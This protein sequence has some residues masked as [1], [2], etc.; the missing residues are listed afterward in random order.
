MRLPTLLLLLLTVGCSML[1][2][3]P[4]DPALTSPSASEDHSDRIAWWREARFGL[5]IHW[6]LY[7]VLA[8]EV[9][10][11]PVG[12]V[13]EWI[14][15]IGRIPKREYSKLLDR[16]DPVAF[17]ADEWARIAKDAGMRYLVITTKHHDGFALF[18]SAVSDFDVMAT[19][20]HRDI[21]AELAA[22]CRRHG[23]R[24][25][26]Y[27][28]ILDW[29]HPDHLP[30]ED[31]HEMSTEGASY[32]R[33]VAFLKSQVTELLTHYGPIDILWFDGEW[34]PTWTNAYA[35]ELESLVRSLQPGILINNRIGKA[36]YP[37][38]TP[39]G[40]PVPGDFGT[41][42]QHIP[43]TGTPGVDW[44][45][46][47]TMND[48][49]GYK[50]ADDHWKS[51]ETL[52]RGLIDI[53]S[54]G[55]NFLLNVGPTG[56]GEIPLPS[57][58]RLAEIGSWLERNGESIY[59]TDASPFEF[60]PWGRATRRALGGDGTRLYLH[61][62]DWPADG[63]LTVPG[64][65]NRAPRAYLLADG[66]RT[67]LD[68]TRVEDA[69][70][71]RVPVTPPD[72]IATVVVLDIDGAPEITAPPR[73]AE[74]LPEFVA[75][76]SVETLGL[77]G[78]DVR[79][80]TDGRSPTASDPIVRDPIRIDATTTIALRHF[81]GDRP[82]SGVRRQTFTRVEPHPATR[83]ADLHPGVRYRYVEGS[84]NSVHELA[85]LPTVSEGVLPCLELTPARIDEHYGL[86]YRGFLRVPVDGMVLFRMRSDDG[87]LLRIDGE[88]IVDHD[89]I[90][91]ATEKTGTIAL[92]AG[93][94][95]IEVLFFEKGGD[96]SIEI[97][98]ERPGETAIP[99]DEDVLFYDG[100]SR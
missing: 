86:E 23:L 73:F 8:G 26:W 50:A 36:R 78:F 3:N 97:T 7:S 35:A 92:A 6:G 18:D 37:E 53:A 79:M 22:A 95:P 66:D 1:P 100:E 59:G 77:A 39:T 41:P 4:T 2:S 88:V 51:T 81:E 48:T 83:V 82:V 49:W 45:T 24:I 25:G 74:A 28:S 20:F 12:G 32:P 71:V 31:W 62:F 30:R 99:V 42:E 61:V 34:Q 40:P 33:Y 9:E 69:L 84:C 27:H 13:G 16:F 67:P 56:R 58:G 76:A 15:H 91:A 43:A 38:V 17:D 57:R 75:H 47:M 52:I 80:T 63:E 87:S 89:G 85:A 11:E 96:E 68:V 94:H 65:A 29:H 60:L 90:H 5:F 70:R 98:M 44:E 93:D 10:G 14:Q 64:L 46:C 21:M 55:G 72:A 19:P 54:K